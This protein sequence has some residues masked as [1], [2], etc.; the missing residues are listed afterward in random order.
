MD[1]TSV[2]RL[3]GLF[4]LTVTMLFTGCAGRKPNPVQ[5]Y[6]YGDNQKSCEHLKC[7][8]SD[9]E[10]QITCKVG[11]CEDTTGKNVALGVTGAIIFWPALFFLD[12]SDADEIELDALRNRYNA[13]VRVCADKKCGYDYQE[14]AQVKPEASAQSTSDFDD[15]SGGSN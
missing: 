4:L 11:E 14:I 15:I 7:E 12:L 6:Q 5:Q 2:L 3:M 8:I 1:K 10:S 9:L 13:L